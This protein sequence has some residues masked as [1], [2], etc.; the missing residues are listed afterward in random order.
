MDLSRE[1]LETLKKRSKE[2]RVYR[3][4]QLIGLDIA[5]LLGDKAHK[6]LYIKLVKEKDP[7]R[8]LAIAKDVSQRKDVRNKGAYFM[9][10]VSKEQ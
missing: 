7:E 3:R 4:Y 6:S 5:V 8:L 10:L 1:Y 2:S 9:S